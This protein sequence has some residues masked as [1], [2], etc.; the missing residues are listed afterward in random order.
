M[1]DRVAVFVD[2]DNISATFAPQIREVAER[3]G[4]V[5]VMRV[6]TDASRNSDWHQTQGYR[7][8]H[9][10][11]GKNAADLLLSID[12]MEIALTQSFTTFVI[13]SSDG[14][15]T[16]L[17]TRLRERG[18]KVVGAGETKAPPGFRSACT[19][20]A[21]LRSAISAPV[22]TTSPTSPGVTDLDRNIRKLIAANS[23]NGSGMR[24][25]E[26]GPKM[27]IMHGVRISQAP[28]RT[29]RAYLSKRTALYDLDER[30]PEARVRFKREGFVE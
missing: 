7:L 13:A 14:D 12:A 24:I 28:E 1:G 5:D 27:H 29:W 30:G 26:L 19:T 11:T 21:L 25:T 9:A 20:F 22:P 18:L 4:A 2:G 6:Y 17:A 3:S 16:H 10:G 15:F 8:I 23:T